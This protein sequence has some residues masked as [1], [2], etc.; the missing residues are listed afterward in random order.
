MSAPL[1]SSLRVTN[2]RRTLVGRK[3]EVKISD[4][5][6]LNIMPMLLLLVGLRG[7][8]RSFAIALPMTRGANY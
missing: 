4:N 7:G 3:P 2:C 8:R 1:E 6:N 5:H